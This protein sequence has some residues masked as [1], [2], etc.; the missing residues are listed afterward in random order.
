MGR[1]VPNEHRRPAVDK[2]APT[3]GLRRG[4]SVTLPA[5]A[6]QED[7]DNALRQPAAEQETQ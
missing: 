1:P 3:A 5:G 7:I 6:T 4:G 2:P